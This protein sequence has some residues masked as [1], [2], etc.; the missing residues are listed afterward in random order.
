MVTILDSLLCWLLSKYYTCEERWAKKKVTTSGVAI[1]GACL[2]H[3][4]LEY[5]MLSK[6]MVRP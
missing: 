1:V 6:T 2:V 5:L 4:H 3:I